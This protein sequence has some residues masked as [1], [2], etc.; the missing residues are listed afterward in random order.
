MLLLF[1]AISTWV[2]I[3]SCIYTQ[4]VY[5]HMYGHYHNHAVV[6][7]ALLGLLQPCFFSFWH[8][9]PYILQHFNEIFFTLVSPVFHYTVATRILSCSELKIKYNIPLFDHKEILIIISVIS[10]K[11]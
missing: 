7:C 9:H 11:T 3:I 8:Y 6:H 10:S 2:F 5:M 1:H 4:V